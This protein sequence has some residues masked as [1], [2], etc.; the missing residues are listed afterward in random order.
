M[1]WLRRRE[2][3][4]SQQMEE[5]TAVSPHN[6][7]GEC[8][9]MRLTEMGF[10]TLSLRL[11]WTQKKSKGQVREQSKGCG[12]PLQHAAGAANRVRAAETQ[13]ESSAK[14]RTRGLRSI[15]IKLEA[16]I[17]TYRHILEDRV[18]LSLNSAATPCQPS[19]DQHF[20]VSYA[21]TQNC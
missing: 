8:C 1:R 15:K 10:T 16:E 2:K 14:P 19:E 12:D 17:A 4:W 3:Y 11:T 6:H 7:R 18:H 13:A 20:R 21:K 9:H 5:S